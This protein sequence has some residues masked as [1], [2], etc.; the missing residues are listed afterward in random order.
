MQ[1][2]ASKFVMLT[3]TPTGTSLSLYDKTKLDL[4]SQGLILPLP[5]L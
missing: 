4:I 3:N 1:S 2:M 5:G